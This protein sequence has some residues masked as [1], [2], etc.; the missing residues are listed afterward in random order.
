MVVGKDSFGDNGKEDDD[1]AYP[2]VKRNYREFDRKYE[3]AMRDPLEA[4]TQNPGSK[5]GAKEEGC[6]VR[7]D[8]REG[9]PEGFFR[10]R[11]DKR[12]DGR[13]KDRSGKI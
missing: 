2:E 11:V 9:R 12:K 13:D 7:Q 4:Q 6:Y 1:G 8:E 3:F 10:Q 5:E